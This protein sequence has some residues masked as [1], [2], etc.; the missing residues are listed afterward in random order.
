EK[1]DD[2]AGSSDT[3]SE[4]EQGDDSDESPSV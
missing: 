2:D 3:G 4:S 1:E